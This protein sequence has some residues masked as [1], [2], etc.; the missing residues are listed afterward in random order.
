M[1]TIGCKASLSERFKYAT[2]PHEDVGEALEELEAWR[3]MAS[4]IETPE[5]LDT[6]EEV[7]AHI[8]KLAE[9][10]EKPSDYDELKSFFEDCVDS[11]NKHWPCAEPYDQNLRQV[12]MEAISRGDVEET[13]E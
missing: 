3:E 9:V 13:E 7:A 10:D 2:V 5:W 6:P 12:I 4:E 8:E 11:L 1:N